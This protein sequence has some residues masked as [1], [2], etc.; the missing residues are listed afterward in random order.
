M[1][2]TIQDIKTKMDKVVEVVADDMATVRVGGANPKMV[3][4]IVIDAYG[5][6]MRMMEVASIT[7]P[8][9]NQI[10]ISP[11]DKGLLKEI[12]K[13]IMES[14]LGIMP[15]ASGDVIR[16]VIP[17]LTEERRQDFVKLIKQ[18]LEGGRVMLKGVRQDGREGIEKMKN[19]SGVSE[20]DVTRLEGEIDKMTVEYNERL[21]KMAQEKEADV[22]RV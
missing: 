5:Q 6:K 19:D 15:S 13:G 20:D 12:E 11:W 14:D 4:N 10:I 22:M 17:P 21:D 9:P 18:K 16:I 7:A 1:D 3:E 8:D 2:K